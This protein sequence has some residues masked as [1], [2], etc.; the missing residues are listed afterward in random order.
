MSEMFKNFQFNNQPNNSRNM[1]MTSTMNRPQSE[2]KEGRSLSKMLSEDAFRYSHRLPEIQNKVQDVSDAQINTKFQ[3]SSLDLTKG[4]RLPRVKM[5]ADDVVLSAALCGGKPDFDRKRLE[6]PKDS[7]N[8][9][10]L[11]KPRLLSPSI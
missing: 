8:S 6:T 7:Q 4:Y 5:S 10:L 9:R 11:S 3:S 2:Q 1:V